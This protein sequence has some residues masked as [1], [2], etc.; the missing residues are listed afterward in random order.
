VLDP[1]TDE[2]RY[3]GE[4]GIGPGQFR[5]PLGLATDAANRLYVVDSDNARI[6]IFTTLD[7]P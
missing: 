2:L 5:R 6:Q 3:V 1:N 4:A 7:A